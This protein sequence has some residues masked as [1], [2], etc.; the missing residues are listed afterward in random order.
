MKPIFQLSTRKYDKE[1]IIVKK[2]MEKLESNCKVKDG[3]EIKEPFAKA[4]WSFFNP[5]FDHVNL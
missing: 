4:G 3:Y 2:A 5:L 1:F